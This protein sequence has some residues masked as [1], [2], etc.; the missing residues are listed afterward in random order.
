MLGGVAPVRGAAQP[1]WV[2]RA[3]LNFLRRHQA[4]TKS[5]AVIATTAKESNC[6]QFTLAT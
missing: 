1:Q 5:P 4:W 6:C 3:K 2:S